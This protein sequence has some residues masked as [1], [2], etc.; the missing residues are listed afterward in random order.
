MPRHRRPRSRRWDNPVSPL[1]AARYERRWEQLEVCRRIHDLC[2]GH[3]PGMP[4]RIEPPK[5]SDWEHGRR[6]PNMA[7]VI[8]LC[9]IY[10]RTPEELGLLERPGIAV[11]DRT[12][13][14]SADSSSGTDLTQPRYATPE[15]ASQ[16][17]EGGDQGSPSDGCS[18][19]M[20]AP[21]LRVLLGEGGSEQMRRDQFIKGIGAAAGAAA[22]DPFVFLSQQAQAEINHTRVGK[23]QVEH[24]TAA[25]YQYA[26]EYFQLAEEGRLRSLLSD[27]VSS[28]RL[29]HLPATLSQRR[30]LFNVYARLSSI[31]GTLALGQLQ[32]DRA[33]VL[34]ETAVDAA[35][36]SGDAE[37]VAWLHGRLSDASDAGRPHG[38]PQKSLELASIGL[39]TLGSSTTLTAANLHNRLARAYA[40]MDD[41]RAALTHLEVARRVI[42]TATVGCWPADPRMPRSFRATEDGLVRTASTVHFRLGDYAA[43]IDSCEQVVA[44]YRGLGLSPRTFTPMTSEIL[45]NAKALLR[46]GELEGATEMA[47]VVVRVYDGVALPSILRGA[48]QFERELTAAAPG[49]RY[50]Q[51]FG[52]LVRSRAA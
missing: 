40:S 14:N 22:I 41:G 44:I 23:E 47:T 48:R 29:L 15:Q 16:P 42:G 12:D 37:L 39:Q 1:Q 32:D 25:T 30:E 35:R 51:E 7:H 13:A 49:S 24:L 3:R 4:C 26:R 10:G 36:E 19:L 18:G 34:F 50:A 5:L 21:L 46:S 33:R 38:S 2:P 27:W 11:P 52:E 17:P 9:R 20:L 31:L 6:L 8:I 43:T 28:Q 45:L